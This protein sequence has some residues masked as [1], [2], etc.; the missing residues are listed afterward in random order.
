MVIEMH[1]QLTLFDDETKSKTDHIAES[2][3]GIYSM[4]KYWSKKPYN[5][6]QNFILR[7]T[8]EDEIVVDPFHQTLQSPNPRT[9]KISA[10]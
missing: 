5:I 9:K 6:I 10:F 1:K 4:H 7:Y 8:N 3:T 2:Y